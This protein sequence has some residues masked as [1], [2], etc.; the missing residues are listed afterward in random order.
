[1]ESL[2]DETLNIHHQINSLIDELPGTFGL[3]SCNYRSMLVA[4]LEEIHSSIK[5]AGGQVRSYGEHLEIRE[6]VDA[7]MQSVLW[8]SKYCSQL[9]PD[10]VGNHLSATGLIDRARNYNLLKMWMTR[11][12]QSECMVNVENNCIVLQDSRSDQSLSRELCDHLAVEFNQKQRDGAGISRVNIREA[13]RLQ[14]EIERYKWDVAG[15]IDFNGFTAEEFHQFLAALIVLTEAAHRANITDKESS[16]TILPKSDWI[17]LISPYLNIGT[18]KLER[19]IEVTTWSLPSAREDNIDMHRFLFYELSKNELAVAPR[20]IPHLN[21]CRALCNWLL[22][23]VELYSNVQDSRGRVFVEKVYAELRKMNITCFPNLKYHNCDTQC[24]TIELDIFT[25]DNADKFALL[26]ELKSAKEPRNIR[27]LS[28]IIQAI[29]LAA[30]VQVPRNLKWLRTHPKLLARAMNIRRERLA[31]YQVESILLS[32]HAIAMDNASNYQIP[33]INVDT[34]LALLHSPN[35]SSLRQL[36][37][38]LVDKS[39]LPIR[40]THFDLEPIVSEFSL[41]HQSFRITKL[42]QKL[43]D[44]AYFDHFST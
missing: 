4:L 6:G 13:I 5:T 12:S 22:V 25:W 40:G 26:L 32:R 7:F 44:Q 20:L 42:N 3:E 43:L 14:F 2:T 18:E 29:E 16:T 10:T 27:E 1:M 31:K 39:Y 17:A 28:N 9:S 19:M 36:Y 24:G 23:K 15:D 8:I 30:L 35:V 41:G 34:F 37:R 38:T 21:T 11:A 33:V